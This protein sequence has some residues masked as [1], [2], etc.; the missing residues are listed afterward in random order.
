[1]ILLIAVM[2]IWGSSFA[3]TKNSVKAVPPIFFALLRMTVASVLLLIVAQFRGGTSKIPRPVPWIII[4]L[5]GLTGTCLYYICFNISLLYTTASVGALIQS[6]I[7][8]VTALLALVFLKER[9]SVKSMLGI[10][11]SI[12]GVLLIIFM[13]GP[14]EKAKNPFLGNMLML[15]SVF[16]WAIY[17]ILAKRIAHIDPIVVTAYSIA[18]GTLL[19]IPLRFL[20]W[21]ASHFRRLERKHG[22]VLFIWEPFRRLSVY[23]YITVP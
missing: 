8:I 3:V 19:L 21:P 4:G 1:M 18:I 20:N 13:A 11:I 14:N 16:I 22:L 2:I 12:T 9:L 10:A 6:F 5:M 7:P 15:A 17:T 23:Y